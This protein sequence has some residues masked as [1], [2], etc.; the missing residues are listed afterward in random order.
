MI[1]IIPPIF[2]HRTGGLMLE[3]IPFFATL[4]ETLRKEIEKIAR[5]ILLKK[6]SILFSPG[7]VTRGFYAV[8]EGAVKVYRISAKGKMITLEIAGPKD[9]FADASIFSDIYHCFAEAL[10]DSKIYLIRKDEFL[11]IIR[12]NVSFSFEWIRILSMEV[13]HLRHRIEE[14]SVKSPRARIIGYFLM[15]ADLQNS[16]LLTL[17]SHR[18][19]IATLLNMTHET[20]YRTA[21]D[22]ENEGLIRFDGQ[23]IE[24]LNYALLEGMIE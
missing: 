19:S 2:L 12:N 18:K 13:I 5:P 1:G 3:K 20:F 17:P 8:I 15:L 24:I 16:H 22:L 6:G 14:L 23:Q 7:D 4:P 10:R 9:T 11:D 21:K